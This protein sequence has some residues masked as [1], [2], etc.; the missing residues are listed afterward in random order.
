MGWYYYL[1]GML[2][3]PF[4]ARCITRRALSP[5]E[6][7][8]EAEAIGMAPEEECEREMFVMIRWGRHGLAVPLSHLVASGIDPRT[9]ADRLGHASPSF[10]LATYAHAASRAQ[11]RAAVVVESD[12]RLPAGTALPNRA[13]G[14][15]VHGSTHAAPKG[16]QENSRRERSPS[17]R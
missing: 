3:F 2:Q 1:E 10:T 12:Q 8:D 4:P 13:Y 6:K 5:L 11:E 7:G 9:V 16:H 15:P 14:S 17:R